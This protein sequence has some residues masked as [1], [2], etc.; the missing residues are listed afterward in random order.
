MAVAKQLGH[1]Q[2]Q[3]RCVE[4]MLSHRKNDVWAVLD[5][6]CRFGLARLQG[7]CLAA[8]QQSSRARLV[9]KAE[10]VMEVAA[11]QAAAQQL[12][13]LPVV[14]MLEKN[15]LAELS[16]ADLGSLVS[17][18]SA[19]EQLGLK[20]LRLG[21]LQSCSSAIGW[22]QLQA[23]PKVCQQLQQRFPDLFAAIKQAASASSAA[24]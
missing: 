18:A 3:D 5:F 24:R 11:R 1:Q 17:Y 20:R 10:R 14:Q 15:L 4:V 13:I 12:D 21:V 22:K 9:D 16:Q 7:S 19:A 2:L 6:G 8:L 23:E